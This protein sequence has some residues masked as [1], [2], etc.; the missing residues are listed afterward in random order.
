MYEWIK[1]LHIIFMVTWFA[2]LFYLP[3][4]FVYHAM[5]EN[6]AS[7][8]LFKIM[9]R[10]LYIMMSLGGALTIIFGLTIFFMNSA[11]YLS[12]TWFPIK[13]VLVALLIAYH[14]WCRQIVITFK[15]DNNRRS[16]KWYRLFNEAPTPL[17]I[18]I[19]IFVVVKINF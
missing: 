14:F 3:R 17:L 11:Y 18:G 12:T 19:V 10:R 15:N 4:L 5:P 16:H 2:G 1:A 6:K 9:E 7:F 13:L 8:E